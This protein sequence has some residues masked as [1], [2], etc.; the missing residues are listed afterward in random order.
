MTNDIFPIW[1]LF[2][3]MIFGFAYGIFLGYIVID[4]TKAILGEK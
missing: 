1:E 3:D 4:A 2:A